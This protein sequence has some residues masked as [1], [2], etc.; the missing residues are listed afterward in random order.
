IAGLMALWRCAPSCEEA[1]EQA[2]A[3]GD[4]LLARSTDYP[5]GCGWI[6][7]EIAPVALAGFAHGVAG[8]A[9]ALDALS[10]ATGIDRFAVRARW[11][12]E[13]ERTLFSDSVENWRD[14]RE[15]GRSGDG[16][17]AAAKFS[18]AWCHGAPGIGLARLA[19]L[20]RTA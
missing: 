20:R 3:C 2:V 7:P 1:I 9:W 18:T 14:V 6:R 15:R 19:M 5:S 11:A 13:Y 4:H 10:H 12:L 8:I 17:D 16:P